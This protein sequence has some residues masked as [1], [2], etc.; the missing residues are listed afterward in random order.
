MLKADILTGRRED[1]GAAPGHQAPGGTATLAGCD[2]VCLGTAPFLFARSVPEYTMLR[3]ARETRVLVVEPFLSPFTEIRVARWQRRRIRRNWGLRQAGDRLWV[4]RPP[5]LG[6]P[7]GTIW[8]WAAE[9]NGGLF[10]RLLAPVLRDL[11]FDHP[12]VWTYLYNSSPIVRRLERR[13]AIY[14]C[15][16]ADTALA[17]TPARRAFVERMEAALCRTVD[18]VLAVTEE[19]AEPRRRLNPNTHA[20]HCAADHEHFGRALDPATAVPADLAVLPRPVIGYMGSADPWKIDVA[21]LRQ[22][23]SVHPEWS[24]VLVGYVWFGFDA[25]VFRECPN[26]YV[27]GGRP[28]ASLPAYLKGMDVCILPAPLNEITL[29]GDALKIYE[30]LAGGKAVVSTP[31][32]AARRFAPLVRVADTHDAFV[33]A[34]EAALADPPA[35][36]DARREA[37][38]PHT[39]DRRVA[40]KARLVRLALATASGKRGRS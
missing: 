2:V 13:L 23:A 25:G 34:V 38:R 33:E 1:V 28:H 27:L 36:V 11:G 20:V 18:L 26:I 4:Y 29:N 14:E 17:G 32:P 37:V 39:W 35:A 10:C 15:V 16:D 9:V 22:L 8:S 5:A 7:G 12:I 30:Y 40:E 19:L 21:L 31:V 3:L 24:I 6:I